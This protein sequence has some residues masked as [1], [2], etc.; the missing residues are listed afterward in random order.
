VSRSRHYLAGGTV[1]ADLMELDVMRPETLIDINALGREYGRMEADASGLRLGGLVH[2]AEAAQHPAF[3]AITP[4]CPTRCGWRRARNCATWQPPAATCCS[5]R[6]ATISAIPA[7]KPATSA[8]PARAAPRS[9]ASTAASPCSGS[10]SGDFAN[11]LAALGANA[12]VLARIRDLPI[13]IE[14]LL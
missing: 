2:M 9:T 10:T 13:R 3:A 8:S 11:A 5:A 6:A 7:G 1:L 12:D 14:D 4:C